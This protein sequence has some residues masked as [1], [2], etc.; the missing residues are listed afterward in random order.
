MQAV[1]RTFPG[2]ELGNETDQQPNVEGDPRRPPP[3]EAH[4]AHLISLIRPAAGLPSSRGRRPPV[5]KV[6]RRRSLVK[7]GHRNGFGSIVGQ[8]AGAVDDI[9]ELNLSQA[10]NVTNTS[11]IRAAVQS[12]MADEGL[13]GPPVE[14]VRFHVFI[15]CTGGS[16]R[17]MVDF[18]DHDMKRGVVIWIRPG[19][20]QQWSE[21]FDA[22]VAVFASSSIPD[23][24]LFDR[25]LGT[26]AVADLGPESTKLQQLIEWMA[27]DLE[28]SHDQAMA[29]SV[30]GV[31][32]RMF[33]RHAGDSGE[34]DDS[35]G[36]RLTM[37]FVD[38]VDRHLDQRSVAWH[39]KQIGASTRSV[40][41]AT[42]ETLQR[43]PKELIDARVILEAQ[44][45]LAW[46]NEDVATIARTL[47]FSEPSNFT[48]FFRT[49]TGMSPSGFRDAVTSI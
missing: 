32:L 19:Q 18:T 12:R 17:H 11:F 40:A 10:V 47:R 48:K 4:C 46:S 9:V 45:R 36:R 22:D 15:H 26:T 1:V 14:L 5:P 27:A 34:G 37:A 24:P 28:S 6:G 3:K 21:G 38:S 31:I 43:R 49:R 23:L 35:P 33:A 29:A 25:F 30:I 8:T 2:H 44:R 13:D 20:V 42:S 16:G 41:R 7:I 39:A